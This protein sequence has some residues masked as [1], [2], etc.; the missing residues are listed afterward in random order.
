M[1]RARSLSLSRFTVVLEECPYKNRQLPELNTYGAVGLGF[2]VAV[3]LILRL[4][5][6]HTSNFSCCAHCDKRQTLRTR[7]H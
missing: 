3:F 6:A 5:R 2:R 7:R 4:R 1:S